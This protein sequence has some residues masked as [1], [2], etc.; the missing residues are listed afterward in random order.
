[1][2]SYRPKPD[3][4]GVRSKYLSLMEPGFGFNFTLMDFNDQTLSDENLL[5]N[6]ESLTRRLIDKDPD[7][8]LGL[9]GVATFFA[10]SIHLTYGAN[11]NVEKQKDYFGFGINVLELINLARPQ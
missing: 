4:P 10:N 9:G 5:E 1:M 7:I 11:L 8:Q 3:E 2:F 6:A